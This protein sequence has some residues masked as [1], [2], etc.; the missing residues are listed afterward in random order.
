M[1]KKQVRFAPPEQERIANLYRCVTTNAIE[2]YQRLR[3]MRV[4]LP[5]DFMFRG[6]KFPFSSLLHLAQSSFFVHEIVANRIDINTL[7]SYNRNALF[8]SSSAEV[9]AALISYNI[10][11][12]QRDLYDRNALFY[13]RDSLTAN[14]LIVNDILI[15]IVDYHG[16][17]ALFHAHSPSVSEVLLNNGVALDHV[18]N[19]GN[20]ALFHAF[21]D[22]NIDQATYLIT[23]G[24]SLY[25]LSNPSQNFYQIIEQIQ[26]RLHGTE[27]N[28]LISTSFAY[29]NNFRN[30]GLFITDVPLENDLYSSISLQLRHNNIEYDNRDLILRIDS[31]LRNHNIN[32]IDYIDIIN[33]ICNIFRADVNVY[34]SRNEYF[35]LQYIHAKPQLTLNLFL[36]EERNHFMSLDRIEPIQNSIIT[37]AINHSYSSCCVPFFGLSMFFS[38]DHSSN[39]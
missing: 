9:A 28:N 35:S 30:S 13:V 33:A 24:A 22:G 26:I 23:R 27:F 4:I 6:T 31:Y 18:D 39:Y 21:S 2:E 36:E 29:Y 1:K 11:I 10:N 15:N 12:N 34:T 17:T 20:T 14:L 3:E 19:L 38:H 5:Q 37:T 32:N 7:D 8:N 16:Q 25:F